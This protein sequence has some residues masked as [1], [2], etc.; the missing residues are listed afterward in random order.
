MNNAFYSMVIEASIPYKTDE[1]LRTLTSYSK[2]DALG[3]LI[4][5]CICGIEFRDRVIKAEYISL[6]AL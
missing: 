5:N 1:T 4:S 2:T 3:T 6:H